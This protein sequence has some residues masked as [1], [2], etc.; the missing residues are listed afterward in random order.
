MSAEVLLL[1]ESHYLGQRCLPFIACLFSITGIEQWGKWV[2][3]WGLSVCAMRKNIRRAFSA[4][5]LLNL[6]Q[7]Q[8]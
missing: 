2:T 4:E 5:A 8:V 3:V 6:I 7:S 1:G